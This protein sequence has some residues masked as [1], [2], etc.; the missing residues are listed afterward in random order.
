ML[1]QFS[2][3]HGGALKQRHLPLN[4]RADRMT[5]WCRKYAH[6][7]TPEDRRLYE[8][9]EQEARERGVGLWQEPE[10]VAPWEWRRRK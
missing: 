9:A 6:E 3:S 2:R 10:P 1:C 7:Q 5:W 8:L 4:W